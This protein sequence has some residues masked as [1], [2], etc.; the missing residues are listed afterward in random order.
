TPIEAL[1]LQ[2]LTYNC[3]KRSQINKVGQ[4]LSM[5]RMKILAIRSLTPENYEEIQTRL[6]ARRF[7]SPTHLL[8]PFA[9]GDEEQKDE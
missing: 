9:E 2:V 8:G 5:W 7:M 3:L 1:D 4:L 6:I